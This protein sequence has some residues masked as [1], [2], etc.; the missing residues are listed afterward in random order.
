L[1][2]SFL[3]L[4][5]IFPQMHLLNVL[6]IFL[7]DLTVQ[8]YFMHKSTNQRGQL[9]FKLASFSVQ[10]PRVGHGEDPHGRRI[11]VKYIWSGHYYIQY[12]STSRLHVRR[13]LS[14]TTGL[15]STW[16]NRPKGQKPFHSF[17]TSPSDIIRRC[18]KMSSSYDL[19][20]K[21]C[22]SNV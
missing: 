14:S 5:K 11:Q 8:K 21:L 1:H 12:L 18:V 6:V 22:D 20:H 9:F 3:K 19:S 10:I 4:F 7:H 15:S 13:D 2:I 16:Q 17:L